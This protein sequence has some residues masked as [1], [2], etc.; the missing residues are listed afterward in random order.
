M[1]WDEHPAVR[2]GDDLTLG[3]RAADRAIAYMGSWAFLGFQTVFI[4][5]WMTLNVVA[6]CTHWDE[7]PWIM[8]NLIFS[9]QAAYA[10]PLILLASRRSDKI[11]SEIALHTYENTQRIGEV[12]ARIDTLTTE[13]HHHITTTT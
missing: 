8:L 7:K 2:T 4:S 10:A 13:V 1:T 6:W 9:I 5:L 12:L 11:A 3:E